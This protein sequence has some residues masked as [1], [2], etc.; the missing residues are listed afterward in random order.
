MGPDLTDLHNA[1]DLDT[2]ASFYLDDF[3][4]DVVVHRSEFSKHVCVVGYC[5][6]VYSPQYQVDQLLALLRIVVKHKLAVRLYSNNLLHLYAINNCLELHQVTK[7][8]R[9]VP[10]SFA[11]Y[12]ALEPR[13]V[14]YAWLENTATPLPQLWRH[15][16]ADLID[17]R[18]LGTV[19]DQLGSDF[20]ALLCRT[21]KLG[22]P[23]KK[24]AKS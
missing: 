13:W 1:F 3:E 12:V 14:R 20:S 5:L 16:T 2:K 24:R 18:V 21:A 23:S 7:R 6:D 9:G 8:G 15:A 10:A 4:E 19:A 11:R 22:A 17:E